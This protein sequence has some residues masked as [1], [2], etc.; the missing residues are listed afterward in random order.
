MIEQ[1]PLKS[2]APEQVSNDLAPSQPAIP[3]GRLAIESALIKMEEDE[4]LPVVIPSEV[5]LETAIEVCVNQV[6]SNQL[7]V[8]NSAMASLLY[9]KHNILSI[10]KF[11]RNF[12]LS[13]KGHYIGDL[14]DVAVCPASYFKLAYLKDSYFADIDEDILALKPTFYRV[15]QDLNQKSTDLYGEVN[16]IQQNLEMRVGF[17]LKALPDILKSYF[18]YIH[19]VKYMEI[20]SF[21][22]RLRHCVRLTEMQWKG[23]GNY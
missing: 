19:L 14:M 16:L 11:M 6:I 22:L 18:N 5:P 17:D 12:F 8:V 23:L 7:S 4:Q 21:V 1:E 15:S 20:F 3:N 10:F 2:P 13:S 9:S